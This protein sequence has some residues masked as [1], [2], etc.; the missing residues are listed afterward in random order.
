MEPTSLGRN[1]IHDKAYHISYVN[2][3]PQPLGKLSL[4]PPSSNALVFLSFA[5]KILKSKLCLLPELFTTFL[6]FQFLY[7]T[8][9]C[10]I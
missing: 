6:P 7:T 10:G 1:G 9:H 2:P 5:V 3:G 8:T 4:K